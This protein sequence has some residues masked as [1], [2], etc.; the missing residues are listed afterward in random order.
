M[1]FYL[2]SDK[3]LQKDELFSWQLCRF[4]G[5]LSWLMIVVKEQVNFAGIR[6]GS[7]W[8]GRREGRELC[9]TTSRG[10]QREDVPTLIKSKLS[11][12]EPRPGFM[13]FLTNSAGKQW[14]GV[15][16]KTSGNVIGLIIIIHYKRRQRHRC[17]R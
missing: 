6:E 13:Y 17:R 16:K 5:S 12:L 15:I 2:F 4:I 11:K 7:L 10:T 1:I 14:G 3:T 9:L 8:Y